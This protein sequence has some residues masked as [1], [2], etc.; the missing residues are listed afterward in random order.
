M[1]NYDAF[2]YLNVNSIC[3]LKIDLSDLSGDKYHFYIRYGDIILLIFKFAL[4]IFI[5]FFCCTGLCFHG[6][7]VFPNPS[8]IEYAVL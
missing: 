7:S 5:F 8:N 6:K 3:L 1:I 2:N 4:L